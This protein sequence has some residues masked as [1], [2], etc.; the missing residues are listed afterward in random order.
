MPPGLPVPQGDTSG[1]PQSSTQKPGCGFPMMG[2]V[3]VLNL[4]HGGWEGFE[5]CDQR[6]HDANIASRLAC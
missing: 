5:T 4:S 1:Y 6:A 3:G 2:I